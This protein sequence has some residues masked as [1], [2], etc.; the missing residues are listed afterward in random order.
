MMEKDIPRRRIY[1]VVEEI[2]SDETSQKMEAKIQQVPNV[3]AKVVGERSIIMPPDTEEEPKK[4]SFSISFWLVFVFVA[5]LVFS[6][7]FA[8]GV[9]VYL[10]GSSGIF[11]DKLDVVSDVSSNSSTNLPEPTVKPTAIPIPKDKLADLKISVLNGSGKVGEASK[12]KDLLEGKGFLVSKTGN[13]DS[14]DFTD[15]LVQTRNNSHGAYEDIRLALGDSYLI[16]LGDALSPKGIYDVV[17][18]VGSSY[19]SPSPSPLP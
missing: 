18:I 10:R 13:A 19:H 4:K 2:T 15:T 8:G 14:Y 5:F 3:E 11:D 7:I 9:F 6:A 16:K 12:V 1:P 17:I